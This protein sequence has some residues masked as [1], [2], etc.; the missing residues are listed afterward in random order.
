MR[1]KV[2]SCFTAVV[3]AMALISASG[4]ATTKAQSV[5]KIDVST[6]AA[7][8][9]FLRSIHVN[10]KHVV[11]QH[12]RR[13]YAGA[14][15]PGKGWVCTTTQHAVVQIARAGGSNRFRCSTARCA[16]VQ[17]SAQAKNAPTT[18]TA[19]CIKTSGLGQSCSINQSSASANNVAIVY[20][21]EPK[22]SGLT[23]TA[24]A[25]ASITQQATGSNSNTA[26]V[27]Q[28][29]AV[30]G[31]TVAK[32][33]TPVAVSLEAH[34]SLAITQDSL[35][36]SN[37][38]AQSATSGG[39]CTG[40]TVTQSQTL[41][42][43]ATGTGPI[44][45]NQDAGNNGFNLSLDIEQNQHTPSATG[46]NT[47]NFTQTSNQNAVA[48][49]P[50]G[51]VTQTQTSPSG[52]ILAAVNQNSTGLSSSVATQTEV[53]CEDAATS[54]LSSCS[55]T[56]DSNTPP[57]LT[58][59]QYGPEG[60][61]KS[62]L[63]TNRRVGFSVHK[64][65]GDSHQTSNP[66]DTFV[67]NQSSTQNSDTQSGQRN[68][69]SGGVNTSGNGTVTQNAL[70]QGNNKVDVQAGT[71]TNVNGTIDC[72]TGSTSCTKTLTAPTITAH[73]SNPATYGSTSFTFTNVD[74]TVAFVCLLDGVTVA[75]PS[76]SNAHGT[77]GTYANGT[78]PSG[79]H[80]F[81]VETQDPANGNVS[82]PTPLFSWV[83]TPPDPQ[84]TPASEPA[85]PETYGGTGAFQFTDT[86]P[87]A[88]FK[89]SL[90]GS[91]YAS[92]T[93]GSV[94]WSGLAS[95]AH[96][97]SVKAYDSTGTYV[98][99]HDAHYNWVITPPDPSITASSEP[100]NPE[101]Y[102]GTGSFQF[103]DTDPTAIFK[104][105]LDGA[106][107]TSCTSGSVSWSGLASGAHSF[108]V[109]A[110]D[111]TG[112]YV[113]N[114][115]AHY[116]WVI[117][118]PDPSITVASEPPDPDFVGNSYTFAFTDTDSSVHYQCQ[119][120]GQTATNCNSGSASYSNLAPG[121]HT[122]SVRAYDQSDTYPSNNPATF[123]WTILPLAVSAL[124]GDDGSSAGWAC[125]PGGPIALTV[126]ST[127]Y[128]PETDIGTFAQVAITSAGGTAIDGLQEPTF[129][130]DNYAAGSPRFVIDLDNGD[131]LWGY[132]SNAGLNGT[133]FAWAIN[134]G[135]TY[136][137]W[138]DVQTAEHG[139]TIVDAVVIADGDQDPGVTDKISDLTFDGTDFNS[140]T[141]PAPPAP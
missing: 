35:H 85:N 2:L 101:T 66:L 65:P 99:N 41:T 15:C 3:A 109:K 115:D 125:Q 45:Q 87:T 33:G 76:T 30:D 54:G 117:T 71:N 28:A 95:G 43:T 106:A 17:V 132:P 13:N 96:S 122:F 88:I 77:T 24:S 39:A 120:D 68:N 7:V 137:P 11:I 1:I 141:C 119:I 111:S 139:A 86:D 25:T 91:S 84:I 72:P 42:S 60:V 108:S 75:C 4:A 74:P 97:F 100:A 83:I 53:Q 22:T 112:T 81:A 5:A 32:K 37:S 23:Q 29:I 116:N 70:I 50:A 12:G 128:D 138:G 44:T 94:S 62:T 36:G 63:R 131:S 21:N 134:N 140:G 127:P 67:V 113:S 121:S 19:T 90:D 123:T 89:C 82:A 114:H 73:P 49:T 61:G 80:T 135:N 8:V 118:P 79:A 51:P 110:Y 78:V 56:P 20:Q 57:H 102:G 126:G 92:C 47:S 129:T 107:Y 27:F 104:C 16:V 52:G 48:N 93:S 38:A 103:T 34:Q 98:S 69:V 133:D 124:G 46:S 55:T 136:E 26:C 9:H 105:S 58:Q 40:S 31:S 6:R 64:T 130:T 59:T 18:N 10:P 14:H